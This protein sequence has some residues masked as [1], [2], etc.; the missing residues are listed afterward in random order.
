MKR[1]STIF[2]KV[3][4]FIGSPILTL[5]IFLLPMVITGLSHV[6]PVSAYLQ[7]I[8]FIGLYGAVMPFL[9]ALYQ[10]IKFLS[11]VNK[12][13]AVS[14]QSL[15]ALKNAR[16]CGITVSVLYVIAMPLL[17]LMAD[18]DDAPG[19]ILFALLVILSTSVSAVF[20]NVFEKRCNS[21]KIS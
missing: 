16:Y 14:E 11:Y 3:A 9:F 5:F 10:T 18:G 20:A 13:N 12:N 4:V 2:L 21:N 7:Y 8:G 17:F 15:N 6:I 19:I 1:S